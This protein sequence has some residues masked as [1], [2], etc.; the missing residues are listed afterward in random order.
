MT[1]LSRRY[2]LQIA[3]A[4]AAVS[5]TA[6][7]ALHP[8]ASPFAE[9]LRRSRFATYDPAIRQTYR[10]PSAN[11]HRGDWGL[12]RPI[13]LRRRGA[14]IT[15]NEEFDRHAH[16]VEWDNAESEVRFLRR[17]EEMGIKPRL[18]V[19]TP[20][21]KNV[22]NA[23]FQLLLDSDFC[24]GEGYELDSIAENNIE[25]QNVSLGLEGLGNKGPGEYGANRGPPKQHTDFS[26]QVTENLDAMSAKEF[27]RYL[28]KLRKLRP[29]FREFVEEQ[30]KSQ[31]SSLYSMAQT[32]EQCHHRRFLQKHRSDE[33][34]S[35]KITIRQQPHPIAGLT[36]SQ[37]S[38][39]DK[40]F[41]TKPQPGIILN[42]VPPRNPGH[43][44]NKPKEVEA[45]VV[46]FGGLTATLSKSDAGG[47]MPVLDPESEIGVDPARIDESIADMRPEII[48]LLVPPTVVGRGVTGLDG[49][50]IEAHVTAN[51][52]QFGI[53]NPYLPGTIKY[54]TCPPKSRKGAAREFTNGLERRA[55]N[56]SER[57]QIISA[58]D[59]SRA[60][61][62]AKL[63]GM[64][65]ST[66]PRTYGGFIDESDD[67]L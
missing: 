45:F 38:L 57:P 39:L 9:L 30:T 52:S 13:S 24:P 53:E 44:S 20:W 58:S 35:P 62:I 29:A 16:Y 47:K 3:M 56:I 19:G 36:Y 6:Q 49:V 7:A 25:K 61:V 66:P 22:G 8:P 51:D 42:R 15:I 4:T 41:Y 65:V 31:D 40:R 64:V 34:D 32:H 14:F 10:A 67:D 33:L 63:Q 21:Q 27:S 11:A 26:G 23:R 1:T 48:D 2:Q 60:A 54:N 50:Q 59:A 17:I 46:S 55:W 5:S 28:R 43:F 12:K 18:K 37:P